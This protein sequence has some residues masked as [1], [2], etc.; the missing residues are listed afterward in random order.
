MN[1]GRTNYMHVQSMLQAYNMYITCVFGHVT[2]KQQ[3]YNNHIT[4]V[5][6]NKGLQ[7]L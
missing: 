6:H 3:Y 2:C 1:V 4:F 7:M 5:L